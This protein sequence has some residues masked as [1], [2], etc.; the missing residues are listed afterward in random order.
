MKKRNLAVI[1]ILGIVTLGFYDLYWT[2]VTRK[3][4]VARGARIPSFWWLASPVILLTIITGILFGLNFTVRNGSADTVNSAI[5]IFNIVSVLAGAGA[6]LV[7]IPYAIYW[8]YQYSKAVEWLTQGRLAAG[9]SLAILILTYIFNVGFVWPAIVQNYFNELQPIAYPPQ[10]PPMSASGDPN[11][12]QQAPTPP[13][14]PVTAS[15]P[16]PPP[17]PPTQQPSQHSSHNPQPPKNPFSV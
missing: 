6:V 1:V 12:Y 8:Y 4:M 9:N 15:L 16:Q 10:A 14:V 17:V 13:P 3:E 2:Y 7:I 11:A 5:V